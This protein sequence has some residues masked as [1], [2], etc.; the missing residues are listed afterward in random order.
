MHDHFTRIRELVRPVVLV[1]TD[2]ANA[3]G[4]RLAVIGIS[5]DALQAFA[6]RDCDAISRA[7]NRGILNRSSPLDLLRWAAECRL[8]A[9]GLTQA[10]ARAE[11]EALRKH[12]CTVL[13][14]PLV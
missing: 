5:T 1:D 3:S 10:Q 6:G 2:P 9:R 12:I 8:V 13:D 4:S 11:V 7:V 14:L